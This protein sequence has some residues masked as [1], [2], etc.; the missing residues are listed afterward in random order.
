MNY[1]IP[2]TFAF[3]CLSSLSIAHG[4]TATTDPVGVMEANVNDTADQQ[5]GIPFLRPP[6]FVSA[7]DTV[8]SNTV[9]VT[10]TVPDITTEAHY[11]H[12]TSG[13]LK[14][15]WYEV[16]S[17]SSNSITVAEDLQAVGLAASDSFDVRPFWTLDTL[18]PNG[19]DIPESDDPFNPIALIMLN[20]P[21]SI[22]T[23]FAAASFYFYH[24]GSLAAAGWYNNDDLSSAGNTII[25]PESY[26]TVR[27]LKES[28]AP[29]AIT[30]IVPTVSL[31]NDVV[32]RS[33]GAQD[34]QLQNPYPKALTLANSDLIVDGVVRKSPDPFNPL[35]LLMIFSQNNLGINSSPASFYFY[36][37]GS[38]AA[39]GWYNN[40]DLSSA[41]FVEIQAGGA[42]IVR[43][44][45]GADEVITWNPNLPYSL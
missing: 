33:V 32:S 7:V 18:L 3:A 29:I 23:N 31:A 43:R 9:N 21:T 15:N 28:A 24:D 2:I 6:T 10:A 26:I 12:I 27:N 11:I 14:G 17:N 35:D 4:Q 5:L 20:D 44:G 8:S 22:G 45:A 19:G 34:N 40:N 16:T 30:G 37:D 1:R 25:S 38:Q 39:E 41:D 42:F 36:H 13:A